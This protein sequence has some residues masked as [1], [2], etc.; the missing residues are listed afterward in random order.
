MSRK[1]NFCLQFQNF[2]LVTSKL[3]KLQPFKKFWDTLYQKNFITE[4][5]NSIHFVITCKISVS[6]HQYSQSYRHLKSVKEKFPSPFA[7]NGFFR[8][9]DILVCVCVLRHQLLAGGRGGDRGRGRVGTTRAS[10]PWPRSTAARS[11]SPP[12]RHARRCRACCAPP[13]SAAPRTRSGPAA[14]GWACCLSLLR[15]NHTKTN[16]T[17]C[18]QK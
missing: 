3:M 13:A 14:E 16:H 11:A 9:S 18:F 7:T 6:Y 8:R 1:H 2:R 5:K 10:I 12:C 15:S 17:R 4:I